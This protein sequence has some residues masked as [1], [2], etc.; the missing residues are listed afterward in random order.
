MMLRM[1]WEEVVVVVEKEGPAALSPK[2]WGS[3]IILPSACGE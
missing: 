2:P 1:G 3:G